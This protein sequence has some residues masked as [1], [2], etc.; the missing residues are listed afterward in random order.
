MP[1]AH[2]IGLFGWVFC[3]LSCGGDSTAVP[4]G[5]DPGK[6]TTLS[7]DLTDKSQ[8]SLAPTH[9]DQEIAAAFQKVAPDILRL[10]RPRMT[11][12]EASLEVSLSGYLFSVRAELRYG[13]LL[14]QRPHTALLRFMVSDVGVVTGCTLQDPVPKA[15]TTSCPQF[16]EKLA[17]LLKP[18]LKK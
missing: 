3:A 11:L 14:R 12:Q 4:S 1:I 13:S 18:Y 5:A 17:T 15:S 8:V 9:T 7:G 16:E 6:Q 10:F 2:K